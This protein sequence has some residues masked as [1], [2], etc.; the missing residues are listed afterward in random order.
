MVRY[1]SEESLPDGRNFHAFKKG[2]RKKE[3]G[4]SAL[5][6]RVRLRIG[7]YTFTAL[8]GAIPNPG[9]VCELLLRKGATP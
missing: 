8:E 9:G 2:E 6:G 5:G 3:K 1:F 4:I 7:L